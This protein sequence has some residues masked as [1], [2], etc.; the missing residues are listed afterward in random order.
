MIF[1]N[2]EKNLQ[3]I[4]FN[5]ESFTIAYD[6]IKIIQIYLKEIF[7]GY[8]ETNV[9]IQLNKSGLIEITMPTRAMLDKKGLVWRWELLPMLKEKMKNIPLNIVFR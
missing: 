1:N 4:T 5:Q 7:R 6:E 2:V 9:L 8:M 3:L